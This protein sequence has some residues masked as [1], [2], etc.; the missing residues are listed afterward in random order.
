[1]LGA[2]SLQGVQTYSLE[3]TLYCLVSLKSTV[4]TAGS[5]GTVE[6]AMVR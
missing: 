6:R 5:S 3:V 2:L 4:L 1:M